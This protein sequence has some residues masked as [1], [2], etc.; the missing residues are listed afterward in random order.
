[1]R[2]VRGV[3]IFL[4]MILHYLGWAGIVLGVIAIIS[5]NTSRGMELLIGGAG[6][7]TLKYV[8]GFIFLGIVALINRRKV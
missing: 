7:L 8:I 2:Y 4:Q 6:F 3:V 1:M 5:S